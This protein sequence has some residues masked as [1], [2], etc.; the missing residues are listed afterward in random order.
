MAFELYNLPADH[1]DFNLR[2]GLKEVWKS[3]KNLSNNQKE[4]PGLIQLSVSSPPIKRG[5]NKKKSQLATI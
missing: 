2:L 4:S 3:L 5:E 1:R